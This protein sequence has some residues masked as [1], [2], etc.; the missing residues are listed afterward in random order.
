MWPILTDPGTEGYLSVTTLDKKLACTAEKEKFIFL[1]CLAMAEPVLGM[2]LFVLAQTQKRGLY[3][4]RYPLSFPEVL[5]YYPP[6]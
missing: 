4:P 3:S 6:L 1:G 2:L 5:E